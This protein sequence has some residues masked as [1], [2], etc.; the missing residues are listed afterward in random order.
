MLQDSFLFFDINTAKPS[1]TRAPPPNKVRT[2][3]MHIEGMWS[4]LHKIHS[5]TLLLVLLLFIT[6]TRF[7]VVEFASHK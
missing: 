5:A 1:P 3:S 6:A 7:I 2:H 4:Q